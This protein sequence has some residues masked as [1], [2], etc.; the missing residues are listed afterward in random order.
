MMLDKIM[1]AGF[2]GAGLG[3][4]ALVLGL[5]LDTLLSQVG[6]LLMLAAAAW[7]VVGL[8]AGFISDRRGQGQGARKSRP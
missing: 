7:L 8:L 6:V 2:A 1:I 4:A 3:L 5:W